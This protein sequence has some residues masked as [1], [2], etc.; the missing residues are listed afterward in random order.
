M[1]PSD[2]QPEDPQ[3]TWDPQGLWQSQKKEYDPMS[4]AQIHD[5]ALAFE[6]TVRKRNTIEFVT[7]AFAIGVAVA[8]QFQP[9]MTPLIRAGIALM[10]L[11]LLFVAWQLHRRASAETAPPIG[12][13]LVE[14]YRNQLIRQRDAGR[15]GFWW[16][17]AP[18][19]PGLAVLIAGLWLK[20]SI[21]GEPKPRMYLEIAL[22]ALVMVAGFAWAAYLI[23]AGVKSLQKKIDEL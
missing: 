1:S 14:A 21:A 17:L 19:F 7:Y 3:G 6:R 20:Q 15:T 16:Y 2:H 18:Q 12:E 11:G 5:Q 4:L 13:S 8:V 10:V 9:H 22:L 23:R